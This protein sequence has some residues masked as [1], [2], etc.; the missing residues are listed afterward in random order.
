MWRKIRTE[1][2]SKWNLIR[3]FGFL[4]NRLPRVQ[5]LN[6]KEIT[7]LRPL[8]T[9]EMLIHLAGADGRRLDEPTY[10]LDRIIKLEESKEFKN[11]SRK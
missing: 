9:K 4:R 11:W 7:S 3:K 10:N 8:R 6:A 1:A 5:Y 2:A